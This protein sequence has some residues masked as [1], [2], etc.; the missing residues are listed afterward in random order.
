MHSVARNWPFHL[1]FPAGPALA[2]SLPPWTL[3]SSSA[4]AGRHHA[5]ICCRARTARIRAGSAATVTAATRA[6]VNTVMPSDWRARRIHAVKRIGIGMIRLYRVAFAWLPSSCRY[7][8]TCSR[9]TEQAIE[10]YGIDVERGN[11]WDS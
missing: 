3:N 6:R 4:A 2:P 11:P 10:K 7:E 8:P 5:A 1:V 9:Y